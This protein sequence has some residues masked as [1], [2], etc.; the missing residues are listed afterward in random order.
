MFLIEKLIDYSGTVSAWGIK[1]LVKFLLSLN[2]CISCAALHL[3]CEA[4]DTRQ[5]CQHGLSPF[6]QI[7][8]WW[9]I[10][11]LSQEHWHFPFCIFFFFGSTKW[12]FIYVASFLGGQRFPCVCE[13][14]LSYL[15]FWWSVSRIYLALGWC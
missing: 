3:C 6:L 11:F 1:T 9:R 4:A 14:L 10:F 5:P 7:V 12:S 13:E 2:V 15:F 8:P